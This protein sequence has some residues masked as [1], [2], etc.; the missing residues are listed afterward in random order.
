MVMMM[1]TLTIQPGGHTYILRDM[2][3]T[4]VDRKEISDCKYADMALAHIKRKA[5]SKA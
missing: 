3:K 2:V 1:R 5:G 4:I